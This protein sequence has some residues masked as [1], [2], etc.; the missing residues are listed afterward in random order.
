MDREEL[1]NV[2]TFVQIA[3]RLMPGKQPNSKIDI[4]IRAPVFPALTQAFASPPETNSNA[5]LLTPSKD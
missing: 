5:R 2:G 4:A 1:F 3:G